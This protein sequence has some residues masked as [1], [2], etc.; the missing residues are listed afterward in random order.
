MISAKKIQG[1]RKR[2]EVRLIVHEQFYYF[3]VLTCSWVKGDHMCIP[4]YNQPKK[5]ER[6]RR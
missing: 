2:C 6:G 1:T 5:V 4:V 3:T